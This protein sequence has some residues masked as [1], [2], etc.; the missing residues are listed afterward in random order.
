MFSD[1]R[2]STSDIPPTDPTLLQ[3]IDLSQSK[4]DTSQE[5]DVA[6]VPY[7]QI[8]IP[9]FTFSGVLLC[10]QLHVHRVHSILLLKL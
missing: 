7:H 10:S 8:E 5:A 2:Q 3:S 6:A 4:E 9:F 1:Y